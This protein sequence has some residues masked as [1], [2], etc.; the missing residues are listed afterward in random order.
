MYINCVLPIMCRPTN[1]NLK[2]K[3]LNS[4]SNNTIVKYRCDCFV[5]S[6]SYIM[7][8]TKMYI[9]IPQTM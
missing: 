3:T 2:L 1:D 7:D 9:T 5:A 8:P 4:I 6:L